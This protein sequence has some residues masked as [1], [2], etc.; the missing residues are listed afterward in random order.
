MKKTLDQT[1]QTLHRFAF[2]PGAFVEASLLATQRG[3]C[4]GR[5]SFDGRSLMQLA[6][7]WLFA[8]LL[9]LLP[10]SPLIAAGSAPEISLSLRGPT[11]QTIEQGEPLR[12]VV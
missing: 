5:A 8:F 12:I 7:A 4:C 1:D 9:G 11:D 3:R 10:V 2:T 6:V